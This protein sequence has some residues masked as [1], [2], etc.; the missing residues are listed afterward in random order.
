MPS[1][2]D[3]LWVND[4][5][6][7]F[8]ACVLYSKFVC[9][10]T[11][12]RLSAHEWFSGLWSNLSSHHTEEETETPATK[13]ALSFTSYCQNQFILTWDLAGRNG[14]LWEV[15]E[16]YCKHL[17]RSFFLCLKNNMWRCMRPVSLMEHRLIEIKTSEMPV[18]YICKI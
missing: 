15:G 12:H 3:I 5:Y 18:S 1:Q 7:F 2:C 10:F 6:S 11:C 17:L 8:K 9:I 4:I 13:D 14:N 16:G